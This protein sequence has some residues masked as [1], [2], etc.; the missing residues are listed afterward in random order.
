[1][2]KIIKMTDEYREQLKREFAEVLLQARCTDGKLSFT[3]TFDAM[4]NKANL[5]FSEK[6]WT[7]MW[8]LIREFDKEVAWH[9]VAHRGDG[10]EDDYYIEDIL[11][12]PQEVTGATVNTDQERYQTWLYQFD[13]DIFN[14]IRMQGH[15]HVNMPTTPSGVDIT[16]Q[17]KILEQ[18]DDD[19]FYIFLIYNKRGDHTI[20]I[21]DLAKNT[22]FENK[23]VTVQIIEDP[24]GIE[25]FVREA[26]EMVK[27][28]VY[29]APTRPASLTAPVT[30]EPG[31]QNPNAQN[32][33]SSAPITPIGKTAASTVVDNV[34]R[35][36][37]AQPSAKQSGKKSGKKEKKKTRYGVGSG[38]Q[39]AMPGFGDED[40]PYGP[41]GYSDQFFRED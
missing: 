18:L 7:K 2:S 30:T 8:A 15:S 24:D 19:M 5:F 16:H 37:G 27:D 17:E 25:R 21:Y 9:G 12:Y 14:N 40:D 4:E 39:A 38:G 34:T 26:K 35:M 10:E 11:V 36:N 22:L 33:P 32:V 3:R 31:A 6:A 20:K 23:D 28:R 1:M 13:D 29:T 41:F